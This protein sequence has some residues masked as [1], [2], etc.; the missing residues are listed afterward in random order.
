MRLEWDHSDN[1]WT[2]RSYRVVTGAGDVFDS[3]DSQP[4]LDELRKCERRVGERIDLWQSGL[5]C[6][7]CGGEI[8]GRFGATEKGNLLCWECARSTQHSRE[9]DVVVNTDPTKA[10]ISESELHEK[11]LCDYVINVATGCRHGCKFCYVPTTPAV[12]HREEMLSDR[13]DVE[14]TQADWGSYL[15]YRDDLPERLS[16]ELD[17]WDTESDWKRTERGRGVVMLSSG[18]DCY[19]DRRAAQITRDCIH[20]LLDR[21]IPVRVL[22][23]SPAVTQDVD[24]FRNAGDL[25]AVG[26]SIPSFDS[27]LTRALEPGAPPPKARW[28]AL[29]R[30]KRAGVRVYVSFSPTYP[31][32]SQSEIDL[33]LGHFRALG[34]DIVVFH[35][36]VNPRG[37]NFEL[38]RDAAAEAGRE[39]VAAAFDRLQNEQEWVRYAIEQIDLVQQRAAEL[40]PDLHVHS[41]PDR[42]LVQHTSG[43]LSRRLQAMRES[44]SPEPFGDGSVL[45]SPAQSPLSAD[46]VI[47]RMV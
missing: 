31:T 18:T 47:E 4:S 33:L 10:V 46:D 6:T 29:D 24:L 35:E 16:R 41:W 23:R 43:D 11:S 14:E 39:E 27:E 1:D 40:Y 20:E 12:K 44:V 38:L 30:L 25:L 34:E 19:Q 21:E 8:N 26:T 17:S 7:D 9:A 42:R 28:R 32:M 15:L 22:T 36:P 3:Y 13:V 5:L 45:S 37:K 2:D